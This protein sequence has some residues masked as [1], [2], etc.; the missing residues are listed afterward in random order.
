MAGLFN[1][2]SFR[3]MEQGLDYINRQKNVVAQNIAN[4]DTPGYKS[5]YLTF[6]G[7]LRDRLSQNARYKKELHLKQHLFVDEDTKGQPDGNNVDYEVQ[8]AMLKSNALRQEAVINQID[9]EFRMMR[10]AMRKN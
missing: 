7:V 2:T 9:A 4:I 6:S 10:A 8:A 3:I 5:K 1:T